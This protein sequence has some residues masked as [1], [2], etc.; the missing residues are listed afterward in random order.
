MRR[1]LKGNELPGYLFRCVCGFGPYPFLWLW[2]G[3]APH[4]GLCPVHPRGS[5]GGGIGLVIA[6]S[7]AAFIGVFLGSRP[8]TKITMRAIQGVVGV[9]LLL[10]VRRMGSSRH[11][12]GALDK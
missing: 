3:D 12:G 11:P 8:L 4:A 6:G 7:L 1:S 10:A 2:T 5:G 9:T